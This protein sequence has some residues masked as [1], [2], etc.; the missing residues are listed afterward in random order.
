MIYE[1]RVIGVNVRV[2]DGDEVSFISFDEVVHVVKF[3]SREL[4][5]VKDKVFVVL[6]VKDVHPEDVDWE[7]VRV[8]VVI[9]LDHDVSRNICIFAEMESKRVDRWHGGRS[10]KRSQ[11]F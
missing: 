6:C 5:T 7:S 11:I 1:V 10:G 2:G 4:F 8:E 3:V 9:S